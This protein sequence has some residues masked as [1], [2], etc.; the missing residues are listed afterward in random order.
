M[1]IL[2][3]TDLY[4][5][6][7]NGVVISVINLKKGL[8]AQG[9][10]VKVLTLSQSIHSMKMGDIYYL[11]SVSS[12]GVYPGTR[13][14]VRMP[15]KI[16]KE[17]VSWRPEIVHSQCEFS[18]FRFA[19]KIAKE[20]RATLVHT[21]H[22]V[23]EEYTHYFCPSKV[24]GKYL[25]AK[26]SKH[27][28][29]KADLVIAP[30]WKVEGIIK[31]YGVTSPVFVVPSG[32]DFETFAK[33]PSRQ[34]ISEKK[35]EYGLKKQCL[36]LIYVG[37]LA[38]EKNVNELLELVA[39]CKE[40]PIKL[41]IVGDG[42]I[43][44]ELEKKAQKLGVSDRVA[45]TGMVKPKDV[46]KYYH[47]GDVFVNA[48]TSE[49]QGLTYIEAMAAGLPMIC[50]R[51]DCLNQLIKDGVNG[52]QYHSHSEFRHLVRLIDNDITLRAKMS[53]NSMA[54]ARKYSTTAFAK[55]MAE[56]Y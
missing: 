33:M 48:S 12:G 44:A 55:K 14:C 34:W 2:I 22:T 25:I 54:Q 11:G 52:W 7:I 5:P 42:P 56:I 39:C 46:W 21:Y 41:L 6:L 19:S 8:E 30:S 10:K 28:L 31:H 17:I 27:I 23:Y 16:L 45:F 20:C 1:K 18:T 4:M 9:H 32:I 50:K 47:L 24:L 15:D 53:D 49:T 38:K 43:R 13:F 40:M 3:T 26:F 29:N 35:A 51:D 37:R 36:T